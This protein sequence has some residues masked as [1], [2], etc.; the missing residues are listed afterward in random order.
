[1]AEKIKNKTLVVGAIN[2]SFVV[3]SVSNHSSKTGIGAHN[4]FLGQVRADSIDGKKVVAIEY[5]AYEEMAE[6][7][8][9]EISEQALEKFTLS[10]LHICHS[11]GLVKAGEICFFVFVSSP[12]RKAAFDACRWVVDE[13][14]KTVPVWGKEIFED[15]TYQWKENN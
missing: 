4:I 8:F 6:D 3:Q 7:K 13:V 12:H 11:T 9:A 10:C 5:E 1:M 14:K 15:N 2:P